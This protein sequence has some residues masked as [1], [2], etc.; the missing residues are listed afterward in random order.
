MEDS[1]LTIEANFEIT[2]ENVK[3]ILDHLETGEIDPEIIQLEKEILDETPSIVD[4]TEVPKKKK[5]YL[6]NKDLLAEVL[7][8]KKQSQM[9]HNLA[10]M[11]QTLCRRYSKKG[12]FASY[13]YN[14]DMQSYAILMLV[15]TWAAFNENRGKNPFAFYTQCIQN[16]FKQYLNLE[17]KQANI[18]NETLISMGKKPSFNYMAEY[19]E[20]RKSS[21][22]LWDYSDS[23]S[24]RNSE[25]IEE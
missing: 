4:T 20:E 11:L 13:S 6:N 2:P 7:E 1:N 24:F 14:E 19:E 17:K 8:S 9:T 21:R 3:E 18:K 12:Q 23:P 10:V 25:T 16:S 15:K 5:N 22:E